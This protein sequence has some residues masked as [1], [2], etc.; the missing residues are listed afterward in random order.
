[1]TRSKKMHCDTCSTT[2]PI[3]GSCNPKWLPTNNLS[4]TVWEC[5]SCHAQKP[6]RICNSKVTKLIDSDAGLDAII[7][8][9]IADREPKDLTT[10]LEAANASP[11]HSVTKFGSRPVIRM[12]SRY[13][14]SVIFWEDGTCT[15]GDIDQTIATNMTMAVARKLLTL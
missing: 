4:D 1:M 9:M 11:K 7:D 15:R 13:G 5:S 6:R 3:H 12:G 10:L 14:P 2:D 8:Q